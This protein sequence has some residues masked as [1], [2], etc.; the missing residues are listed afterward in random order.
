[1]TAPTIKEARERV[2]RALRR[3][4]NIESI[5]LEVSVADA[6]A[7][8]DFQDRC[9]AALRPFAIDHLKH[10]CGC[11]QHQVAAA[12]VAEGDGR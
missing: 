8:L 6:E 5:S 10:E 9:L 2:E 12:L 11:A 3:A 7:L 1:M 4:M